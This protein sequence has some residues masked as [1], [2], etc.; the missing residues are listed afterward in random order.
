VEIT[1]AEVRPNQEIVISTESSVYLFC[2][3]D[4]VEC[5]GV[6]TGGALGSKFREVYFAGSRHPCGL[7]GRDSKTL[8]TGTQA[9]FFMERKGCVERLTTS[10]IIDLKM[11][12]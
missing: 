4:P 9:C 3:T 5:L 6:L 8:E 2:V 7:D 12:V 10:L 1:L 11:P